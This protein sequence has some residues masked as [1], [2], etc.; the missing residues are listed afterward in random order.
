MR[1]NLAS[2][3]IRFKIR[4]VANFGSL[5][6]QANII[7]IPVNRP[8]MRETTALGAAIAAGFAVDIWKEFD[9]LKDINQK[10]RV[11]FEPNISKQ[12]SAKMFKKWSRAVE[13]CRGWLDSDE[14]GDDF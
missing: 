10:D 7:G 14:N 13:M 2:R 6:T 8:S 11:I 9:E 3:I 1:S 5:Q 4:S 12:E